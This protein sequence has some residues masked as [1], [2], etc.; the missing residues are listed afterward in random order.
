MAALPSSSSPTSGHA[1]QKQDCVTCPLALCPL[2]STVSDLRRNPINT[3]FTH[4]GICSERMS[5][6]PK[7]TQPING[8]A[9]VWTWV[10]HVPPHHPLAP[11][12]G[13]YSNSSEGSFTFRETS[14]TR[15]S[16]AEASC[17]CMWDPNFLVGT[18]L[19]CPLDT[20]VLF[21]PQ[22]PPKPL[23]VFGGAQEWKELSFTADQA[24]PLHLNSTI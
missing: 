14:V 22:C 15:G 4:W 12:P 6:L 2:P 24:I 11:A 3:C 1:C 19:P 10:C 9:K 13:C 16:L 7:L 21:R 23:W 18:P 8:R 20:Q 5:N 17:V